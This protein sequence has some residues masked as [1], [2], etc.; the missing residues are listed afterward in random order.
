MGVLY[1]EDKTLIKEVHWP[2]FVAIGSLLVIVLLKKR[3][4]DG[5]F[6]SGVMILFLLY[7]IIFSCTLNIFFYGYIPSYESLL[8]HH[9]TLLL[10]TVLAFLLVS[11]L[12]VDLILRGIYRF[13]IFVA[14]IFIMTRLTSFDFSREG[15]FLGLGPITFARY[16]CVG[17]IAQV[18][19]DRKLKLCPSVIFATALIVSE[20]K[21][22]ILFFIVT[23]TI[24]ML[25]NK[26]IN[27]MVTAFFVI[28]L[29][30]LFLLSGRFEALVSDLRL[31][32]TGEMVIPSVI[33]YELLAS[34]DRIT[35][36]HARI[37]AIYSS[38]ELIT[39]SPLIGWGIGSWPIKTGLVSLEYPHNSILEIW[40]EYG[41]FGFV[42]FLYFLIRSS[43]DVFRGNQ[44]S[45]FVIFCGLVS[46]T[47][48]SIK[49]LRMLC[50][51]ML[52]TYHFMCKSRA[53]PDNLSVKN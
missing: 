48:G 51:F 33:E 52:L 25:V 36:T 22:P 34:E 29:S 18:A 15:N 35:S 41:L 40:I 39:Q 43:L 27:F 53:R 16:I 9:L 47:T 3:L 12:S 46:M 13:M 14:L 17:W 23:V 7:A 19:Y 4:T 2:M 11:D 21:G 1:P 10:T 31:F 26:K 32:F 44:F 8:R 24:W 28:C 42:V 5:I 49:D 30:L 38:V 20:S 37:V 6:S 45:L 50:F